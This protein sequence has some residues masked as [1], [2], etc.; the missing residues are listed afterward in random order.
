MLIRL[1][2]YLA[3]NW[4]ARPGRAKMGRAPGCA[5]ARHT[6][7]LEASIG[8]QFHIICVD[9]IL[10]RVLC[11]PTYTVCCNDFETTWYYISKKS[12]FWQFFM[13]PNFPWNWMDICNM[14]A[15]KRIILHCQVSIDM[16]FD[17]SIFERIG[18]NENVERFLMEID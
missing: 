16:V 14:Y 10:C 6:S 2:G 11:S 8:T 13:W 3:E 4:E 18:I 12:D 9:T 17:I 15:W 1:T 7:L 5:V